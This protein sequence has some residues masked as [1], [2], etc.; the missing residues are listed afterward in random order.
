MLANIPYMFTGPPGSHNSPASTH[1]KFMAALAKA[2]LAQV[3]QNPIKADDFISA[4]K[5]Y[6]CSIATSDECHHRHQFAYAF[7]Q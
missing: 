1:Q 7:L 3:S 6:V 5:R 2:A 4:C